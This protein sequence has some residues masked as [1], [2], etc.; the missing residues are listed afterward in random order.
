MER[1]SHSRAVELTS[2][3]LDRYVTQIVAARRPRRHPAAEAVTHRGQGSAGVPTRL[4]LTA[5]ERCA[6]HDVAA[7][8]AQIN[9]ME[10]E[11]RRFAAKERRGI[12]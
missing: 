7:Y 2:V 9:A 6:N 1:A 8:L 5:G 3:C 10:R 12:Q 11:F 4:S